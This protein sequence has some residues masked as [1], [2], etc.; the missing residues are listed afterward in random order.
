MMQ[1]PIWRWINLTIKHRSNKKFLYFSIIS[2]FLVLIFSIFLF[3][4]LD[5]NECEK[6][7]SSIVNYAKVQCS[8]YKHYN[9][10]SESVG[11]LRAIE[12]AKQISYHLQED[13]VSDTELNEEVLK[14]Y[15]NSFWVHGIV[16]LD[17]NNEEICSFHKDENLKEVI[18]ENIDKAAI[19][20]FSNYSE[21]TYAQRIQFS[22]SSYIDLATCAR[23]DKLG[24][25]I[26]YFY[27]SSEYARNYVLTLQSLLSGYIPSNDGTI[28]VVEDGSV[29]A[30][31]DEN[32]IGQNTQD[33]ITVQT[34]KNKAD[35]E[36]FIHIED[37]KSYGMMVKQRDYYIYAYISD[38][39]VFSTLPIKALLVEFCYLFVLSIIWILLK[40]SNLKHQKL[41][42]E[43]ENQYKE[44]LI[45][46]AKKAEVAN[47]T[48]TQFLQ[49]MSHDIRTPING[50]CGMVEVGD[51]YSNDLEKQAEC[52]KKIKEASHLLLELVNEVLDMGKLE[53]GE[54]VLEQRS[55]NLKQV[56]E[57][58]ITVISKLASERGIEVIMDDVSI[59]HWNLIGSPIHVKRSMMNIMSNAVKY[60]K[61]NGK[62]SLCCR[63]L[64]SSDDR[65]AVIQ[66]ICTDNGIGMSEEY[67][68]KI[69]E[70]FT[71]ENQAHQS[72]YGGTGLGM[73]IAKKLIEKMNGTLT[74]ESKENKG[75]TFIATIP[76]EIDTTVKE[77]TFEQVIEE[78]TD[79][80]KGTH[81]LL[82]EDNELNMEISEFVLE[83]AGASITKA[84][85]GKEALSIFENSKIHAF[86]AI[87][88]DVM[89]PIMDGMEATRIIRSLSRE[90]AQTIPIIAM[91]ANAFSED[92]L[93]TKQAGMNQHIAKPLN[94]EYTIQTIQKVIMESK[95][96]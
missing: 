92:R 44:Q 79:C 37:T 3:Y 95:N 30:C 60:N 94:M 21:R 78:K 75:T 35:N 28:M 22:D 4:G 34:I 52:R 90:D 87:L 2:G 9:Y 68:E 43:K 63:E 86:D 89:M 47:E 76:F 81:I 72:K 45:Q 10:S 32:L 24:V 11:I 31:N 84:W 82:V 18:S 41:E 49:R 59:R 25:I 61:E 85:N 13:S 27:T 83:N 50:I 56:S 54:F 23:L 7:L 62:I 33:N 96:Q 6:K 17:E 46:A 5:K 73:P 74:F 55:F 80:L 57:D 66:F 58:V 91:T 51:Y 39:N 1:V 12:N 19:T 93:K 36:H 88:M 53:S 70:P 77:D 64:K 38:I 20:D 67:Q 15:T 16:I 65:V 69:F 8:T 26:S 42:L 71:Q 40:Q 14:K 48:K 29:V